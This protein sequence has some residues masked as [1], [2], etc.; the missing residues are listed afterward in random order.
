MQ[1]TDRVGRRVRLRDLHMLMA[2]AQSGSIAKAAQQLAISHPVVSKTISDLEHTLGVRLLDR[3]SRG[4]RPTMYGEA[5]LKC[6]VAVFDEMR[7]GIRHVEFLA[8]PTVGNLR[9]GC[10]EAMAAGLIPAVA[11][12]FWRQYPDVALD[13]INADMTL[14]YRE[15]RELDVEFLVGR[16]QMPFVGEDLAAETLFEERLLVVAGNQSPW[17][18]RRR[19]EFA[20]LTGEGWVLP[21]PDTVPGMLTR[22]F[23]RAKGLQYPP[24]KAVTFSIHFTCS[25]LATGRFLALLPESLLRFSGTRLSLKILPVELPPQHSAVGVLTV[26]NR[27]LSPL[28]ERF[29]QCAR[30][31]AKSIPRGRGDHMPRTR[32]SNAS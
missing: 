16:I 28:A 2:V 23:F 9:F 6:G 5:L 31:V 30:E 7:Q 15:L 22:E 10:P 3:S 4:V 32:K 24:P 26:K 27:T 21:P 8:D 12:R 11:E 20:D 18:R 19:V 13:M 1:W 17:A 29:I 25:L 14:K